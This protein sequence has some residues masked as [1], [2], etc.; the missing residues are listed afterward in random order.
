MPAKFRF[1][2]APLLERRT[3]VEQES[4]HRCAVRQH[5]HRGLLEEV[6]RLTGALRACTTPSSNPR[7]A[8]CSSL[9]AAIE[10]QRH[11][12]SDARALLEG[13]RNDAIAA[14]RDLRAIEALR[15]RRRRAFEQEE[16]RREE[17]ELDEANARNRR[18]I[19]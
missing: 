15:E 4:R 2:L 14:R 12:I 5:E 3:L 16:A 6:N 19:R 17:V 9:D 10:A 13:A 7:A 11:R 1:A 8:L 18:A